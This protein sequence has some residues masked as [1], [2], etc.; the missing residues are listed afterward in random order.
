MIYVTDRIGYYYS[1]R[2]SEFSFVEQ[3]YIDNNVTNLGSAD[4]SYP[5]AR[6]SVDTFWETWH[7][8]GLTCRKCLQK[9]QL[10]RGLFT[11]C[12]DV[13]F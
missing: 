3:R 13:I 7:L 4:H 10:H 8:K 12:N 11:Y 1:L 9:K 5:T 2:G 6:A